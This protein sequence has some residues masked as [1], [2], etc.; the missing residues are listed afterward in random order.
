VVAALLL[1]SGLAPFAVLTSEMPRIAAWPLA[2]VAAIAGLRTARCE[3]R[4]PRHRLEIPARGQGGATL[5]GAPLAEAALSWRGPLAF[6]CWRD[7]A[8]RRGRLSWWPDTLPPAQRRVLKLWS[9]GGP[10]MAP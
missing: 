1:L 9:P 4:R 10:G 6:L 5:D 7:D 8:D 2:A 3:A